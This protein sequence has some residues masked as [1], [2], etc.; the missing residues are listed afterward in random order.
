MADTPLQQ[1]LMVV[2][3]QANNTR[4]TL[5]ISPTGDLQLL[6]GK[7][8]L[9]TQML[10]AIVNDDVFTGGILNAR[11]NQNRILTT[12]I[13]TVLRTFRDNQIDYVR[14]S[15]PDLTGYA[16]WRKAAGTNDD[17]VRISNKNITYTFVDSTVLNGMNYTYGVSKIYRNVFE[18]KFVDILDVKPTGQTSSI[19]IITGT[20]STFIPGSNI[21]TVYV[22]YNKRFAASELLETIVDIYSEQDT[23]DPRKWTVVIKI[24]NFK[25]E[26]MTLSSVQFMSGS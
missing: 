22:D 19:Q 4:C 16:I 8:K 23:T 21:V 12:L 7:D 25:D 15:N 17:F 1:D 10:R 5:S 26:Q 3:P 13:T 6:T 24:K 20:A 11:L 18:S 9:I 2:Y 14:Q